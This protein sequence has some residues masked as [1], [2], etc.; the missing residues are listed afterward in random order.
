MIA[1][2]NIASP[3]TVSLLQDL[4]QKIVAG[5]D[6]VGRGP[7]AG[8]VVAAAV[9][10]PRDFEIEGIAD[11]KKLTEAKREKVL[12][13][14]EAQAI[15]LAIG[16]ATVDEIDSINILQ[17]TLLAMVRAVDGL[18]VVP[19]HVLVDGNR[20]PKWNF[21]ATPIIGGDAL[22]PAISAASIVAKVARDKEMVQ[23]GLEYP[24][25]GFEKHK[26]YGT[27]QHL[28][29]LQEYGP[30][31]CHRRSFAPVKKIIEREAMV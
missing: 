5:V 10:L 8:D 1:R 7:L 28:F 24:E 3:K 14:I 15:C 30:L 6:E 25:Y 29:A 22:V 9:I 23:L 21:E 19:E 12:K 16:R 26:G 17:A 31:D 18:S 20:L 11:S 2:N 27:K 13:E 4:Q